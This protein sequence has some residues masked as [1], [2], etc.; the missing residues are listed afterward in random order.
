MG[1]FLIDRVRADRW[2]GFVTG[3]AGRLVLSYRPGEGRQVG[4]FS[5]LTGRGQTGGWLSDE[6]G[7]CVWISFR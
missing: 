7:T 2:V 3:E 5:L 4:W 1:G 6:T